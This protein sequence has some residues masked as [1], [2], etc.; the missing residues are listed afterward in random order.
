MH[1]V[2]YLDLHSYVVYFE[3]F[4]NLLKDFISQISDYS[5]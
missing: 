5:D 2:S 3:Y 4:D 1:V